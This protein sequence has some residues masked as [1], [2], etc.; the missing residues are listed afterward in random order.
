MTDESRSA[1]D[2]SGIGGLPREDPLAAVSPL[3]GRYARRTEPLS[4]YASEAALMR[5]RTRV[6]AEYLIAL[7]DL[8]ATPISLDA[9]ARAA[10]RATYG[11]FDADDARLIKDLEVRGAKGY[12]ATNH[13]VKAVEYFLRIRLAEAAEASANEGDTEPSIDDAEALY[14]W[15][16]FGLTSE[17]VNNLAHRLLL[18][19]AVEEVL[20][21]AI[22]EVRDE[23]VDL[24]H[25]HRDVP[26]LARTHG[27]P[28]T[29][30]TFGKE[31]AVYAA[32]LGR[33]LGRLQ[34]ETDA[35]AGKLAGASGTYAAHEAAYPDVDW[36][37]FSRS[38]VTDLGL[39]HV[40]LAT[41]VNPCDDLAAVFDAVR[42]VN[43][44][45]RD[46][47]LD[48]W[49]YVSDRYLGQ[50]AVEGETG[51]STMPHK[52]NP[53]DFENGEGNLSKANADLTFLADYVTTS[54]LQRDLSD[55]TVKRNVGAALAHSLI[56]YSKTA[57]GLGKVVPN[58]QVMR[59][60][61]EAT[62]A[63]IG[64]A[65]QTILRR[66]GDTDAYERVKELTRGTTVTL[67][68]FRDL[69]AELD[70]DESVREELNALTP[71]G[72]VGL[73][74][75]LVDDIDADGGE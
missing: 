44:V 62:P 72:Y 21:P 30:T 67:A 56:G 64:E 41:Q 52:V 20:A 11:T 22:R 66:E 59:E 47:D 48:A 38:F 73:G 19:P 8:E 63:I 29:P 36:R 12:D 7:A 28:A 45:L 43:N 71:T 54:R 42:G 18:K 27:Q 32:R 3:D 4:P 65:V 58:E 6:E 68:D 9:D 53:I 57:D 51:S 15:I 34:R 23:L 5:A 75:E 33:A 10:I 60:E 74:A 46:L 31:M 2:G 50:E 37:A 55:S 69:F 49:L 35:I 70:V 26:M 25:E 24:A 13:D 61:L 16:H 40:P 17:D 1:T 39:E 14:P